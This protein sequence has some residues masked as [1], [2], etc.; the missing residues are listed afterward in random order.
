[1]DNHILAV[2]NLHKSFGSKKVIKGVNLLVSP[3]DVFGFL[4]P[5][6]AGKTTLIRMLLGLVYPDQGAIKINGFDLKRDFKKAISSIG[7][8]VEAPKFYP[9]LSGYQNIAL[10]AN[11]RKGITKDRITEVLDIVGLSKRGEDKVGT[12][13]LGMKQRLGIAGALVHNPKVV[14]LDEPMNGLDPQGMVKIREMITHLSAHQKTTFI[15]TSH[16]LNEIE[17]I[18]NKIAIL[19]EGQILA[20][21]KVDELLCKKS[22]IVELYTENS[23]QAFNSLQNAHYVRSI[24]QF[25]DK[26]ILEIN[27]DCSGELT[28]FLVSRNIEVK[29]L[30]PKKQSLEDYFIMKTK[31]D[32]QLDQ[33]NQK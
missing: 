7:A 10:I 5:N 4:G 13:S 14:L 17:Q 20:Q 26:L 30:I 32:S 3:G 8:V 25:K 23:E 6:G 2:S 18:C 28:R 16:L 19:K 27:K 33:L 12:Y 29:Y 24:S 31:G 22:E 15:I 1:M 9:H 11:L 21:G